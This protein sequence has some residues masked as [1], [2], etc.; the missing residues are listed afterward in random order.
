[1]RYK[2]A[3]TLVGLKVEVVNDQ[4][5]KALRKFKK[6]VQES[7]LLQELR[8]REFYEKPTTAR[9]KAKNSAQR[10]WQKKLASEALPKKNY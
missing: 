9:K 5:E 6:K 8:E 10:R 3:T 1:M 4:V 2:Q 7:G